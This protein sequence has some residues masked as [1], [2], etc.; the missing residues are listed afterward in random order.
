MFLSQI[1]PSLP[2]DILPGDLDPSNVTLPQIPLHQC[3]FPSAGSYSNF[4]RASNPYSLNLNGI[5]IS[6]SSGQN[7]NDLKK[8][9]TVG[10]NSIC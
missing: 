9:S 10:D 4:S 7:I 2:I 1:L 6:G 5:E 8:F 3:L